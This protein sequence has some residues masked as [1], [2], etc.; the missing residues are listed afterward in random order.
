MKMRP[1]R[2]LRKLRAGKPASCTKFNLNDPRAVEIAGQ[3]GFDCVWFDCEHTPT[4][5]LGLEQAVRAAKIYDMDSLVRVPRGSYSDHIRPFEMD[6]AG[7]MVPHLMSAADAKQVVRMT[8]FHPIGRRPI[9]GGNADG[10][11]C[12]ISPEDYVRTANRERFVI[13]QIEDPEP[14]DELDAI[15]ATPGIDMLFFGPGDFSHSIGKV[16]Q[17]NAPEVAAA[18]E[19]IAKA[20]LKHDKFAGTVSGVNTIP[21]LLDLGYRFL[22]VGADVLALVEYFDAIAKAFS[23]HGFGN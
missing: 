6:A 3:S 20:A 7:I 21:E 10:A 14:L 16:G 9:D 5:S 19:A 12:R 2:V 13:V 11:Y 4:D 8:R 22:S 1:S 17:W 23:D 15:A 18:R